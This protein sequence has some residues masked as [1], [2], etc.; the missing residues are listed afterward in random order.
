M[1]WDVVRRRL[2]SSQCLIGMLMNG[3]CLKVCEL[4]LQ[5]LNLTLTEGHNVQ[6]I[7]SSIVLTLT[8]LLNA[9]P[10]VPP[11]HHVRAP[12]IGA[13]LRTCSLSMPDS[14]PARL[15]SDALEEE[16]VRLPSAIVAAG[17]DGSACHS[18]Q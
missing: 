2:L 11:E 4:L 17:A 7:R 3:R 13:A 9:E 6:S 14:V 18:C 1:Q 12:E 5:F 16:L 8:S 15:R 10:V